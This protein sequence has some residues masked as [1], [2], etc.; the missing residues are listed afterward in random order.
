MISEIILKQSLK[1]FEQTQY[2]LS[3]KILDSEISD[4]DKKAYNKQILATNAL[5]T[6]L[7]KYSQLYIAI[8]KKPIIECVGKQP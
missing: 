3:Q 2:E 6:N 5:I 8:N 7:I 4:D 1:E